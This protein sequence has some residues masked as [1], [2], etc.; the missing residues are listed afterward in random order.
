MSL[1]C[2]QNMGHY[3]VSPSSEWVQC[4][5]YFIS[6]PALSF[7]LNVTSWINLIWHV[8]NNTGIKS[9]QPIG[10]YWKTIDICHLTFPVAKKK[11]KTR[12]CFG[13]LGIRCRW[14]NW[15]GRWK[16]DQSR[17]ELNFGLN[18]IFWSSFKHYEAMRVLVKEFAGNFG[19]RS[20]VNI[21]SAG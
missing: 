6:T 11:E 17:S 2:F 16:F 4:I 13:F 20:I 10:K 21:W 3:F 14:F 18:R 1:L 15:E 9:N 7:L 5:F 8:F 19:V 12:N